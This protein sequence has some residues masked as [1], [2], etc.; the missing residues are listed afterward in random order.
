MSK[1]WP[2]GQ[3]K[4]T[5]SKDTSNP[6]VSQSNTSPASTS[7][8]WEKARDTAI[9][10]LELVANI[11][12]GSDVLASLKA[13]CKATKQILEMARA[14]QNNKEDWKRLAERL[15]SHL[16][17]MENQIT[18]FEGY[19]EESRKVDDSLRQPL[20]AY[21]RKLDGIQKAVEA[22]TRSR[23]LSRGLKVDM[24]AGDIRDFH[25]DINDCHQ[26]LTAALAV[27]S[28]FHIQVVKGDTE[29]LRGDAQVIKEDAKTLLRDADLVII[30]QLP[31]VIASSAV[32]NVCNPG[33]R[34]VVLD[35]IRV[36]GEGAFAEPIFWLCDIAGSGKSTVST[37]VVEF[38]NKKGLLGGHFFFSMASSEES[39]ITK[40]CPTFARQM[41]E[42]IPALAPYVVEAVK[43]HPAIMTRPFEE[44]F[45]KLIVE[46]TR[47]QSTSVILVI[48][49]LDEC[50]SG[51]ERRKLVETLSIAVQE[52]K[53]LKIFITSRPDPV[54]QAVLGSLPIKAQMEDRLHDASHP[55]NIEDIATYIEQVINGMLAE[56]K[57]RRLVK[58]ANG[59][60]IW[61][62]IACRMLKSETTLETHE[63]I[64]DR[65][66]SL[67]QPG[68]IDHIY[69]LI[70][71]RIDP[72]SFTIMFKMLGILLV[73]FEP[74]STDD[75]EDLLKQVGIRGNVNAL[76]QNLGSVLSV[77]RNTNLIRFRHHTLVEYLGRR[78][79]AS[80]VHSHNKVHIN[81]AEAHGQ[82]ASWC[83]KRLVSSTEGVK[84]NIC[85]IESSFYLNRQVAD[86]DSRVSKFI[87]TRLRYASSH[88]LFHF[89]ETDDKQRR[90]L[91][92]DVGR[93][94]RTPNVLHWM[95]IVSLTRG[96]PRAIDGLRTVTRHSGL[97][98]ETR[99]RM[100]DIRR[101]IMAFSVPIQESAAH[102]YISALPFSPKKSLIRIEG[103]SG[104]GNTLS[105]TRGLEE[106]YPGLPGILRGDQGSV[107]AVSFSPDG[108]RIISGSFDKTIRVWDADTGQPLGEP[109]QG[110]EHWVTAVGF[111]PDG[112]I[113]VSGSE[114]K[115][116]RLWE[117]DTGRPLG[118]PLLGHE[119][120]VL[121]VAFS[122]DGSR[123]VSG[124]DD[125]TI[126]LWETDTGQPLGEPL[127]G[128]KSSVSA[129]AFSPDGSRIASASDDKTIRLWEVETGQP[130][131]EPLR[132]HEAGVSAVS[133][134]PDGSQL[135][136]GSIDKTVR[137]WE[138]DT[139][140]LL[141]E[142]LR[143]HED[144]VYAIAFSPDGTKIVSGS[145]DKT[146]RLWER[147]L[148]EPI[149]E[150]LRGH[151][152]CVSTVGFSPDG[153]WVISGS[154]DGTIRLWEVITGQQLGEPPQGHEGSVFTVAFSPDDSKIVSG[155][156]DKTIRLWEADTGQP[157]G[158]PLRGHEGWVN[159]VAFSPDGSLIVS[160]SED[161]TI[162]L[163][164][165]DTG[166]TLREPLR[167]HAGSV[168]AVTFSPD[169]TRIASGSDDDTIRLWEAHTGQPVGQPLRGHERHVNAVMFSPDGTRIV[170][171][172]FDG[173]VR[174]WE[175]DTGQ[176][177]GDPLRGHEVGI[178][179]V[180]FSPDGSRIVS[181]SGDG[182]I[183]LWEA[184]TGQL[185]GEPLKGP[186]LGVNA[187]A[188]SPDGS[189]IVSCSH[190]KTIQF[191]DAN[192]SQ[193]LGEPL[194]GHQSLVFAVAFSSDGSRIV[195]GSSDKTIQIWDT[196]IAASVD[197]SNQNDAEAPE[198]SLQDKLQSSPLSLIVPGFNQCTLSRDGW[199]QSSDK[200]LFWVPPE[201]RHG[202]VY[203]NRLTIPVTS[204]LRTTKVDFTHF[205]CGP[206]WTN[207]RTNSSQ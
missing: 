40:M 80:A 12:E 44:Q 11:S 1:L 159:A 36:W 182:M 192:T 128:H 107:C 115:T 129:V 55:D 56:E 169:G 147:T 118:G 187:L 77:D 123:V 181:A 113:I 15:Q 61:A 122:P 26:R 160:G 142:P 135:A 53:T 34:Q 186:Q 27:S 146:I 18:I 47:H 168:R 155:S 45:Q 177:F 86:L 132:G 6:S 178:N 17:S 119:S 95:E 145:Y 190:D 74:L 157:L 98:E 29:A 105:V 163:W 89:A 121:A 21:V 124:S 22:R 33:T 148:A 207:V 202:L 164:E 133:F 149:G 151:E 69:D 88:W 110:H 189:R 102:I 170:S 156:K 30:S 179:A 127:R 180:A 5:R 97:E 9:P 3:G 82:V 51:P 111:S 206:S 201:N 73:A 8:G 68:D 58:N 138:V 139:G 197:N 199:V 161:R 4:T 205:Q 16:E 152:D 14:I 116:I 41:F 172:S 158:E 136:S 66:V 150:P 19:S 42:N 10:I 20:L 191:W 2:K 50:K 137:L 91:K 28:A 153:S 185:L 112:S 117:A 63:V 130:L 176:P 126:R 79:H 13:A 125:K 76:I 184:D 37:S 194:R 57:K 141:G 167:G 49:A 52:S 131:G 78:S 43:R 71:E 93:I 31:M 67:D 23:L 100:T 70:F 165:V 198:L 143:G 75:L 106:M 38:W 94:I 25:Q 108:S 24:D 39:T 35:S 92:R 196:E 114:D 144:S 96:V 120:P 87:P 85:R 140:Q 171:G 175:A 7:T 103:Q 32:H 59:L 46:P 64:Y 134:S 193:S 48:D 109:L 200:Y 99:A 173:T 162:R 90:A 166:Q 174:L 204:S 65:L 101:F 54:I 104:H 188:F 83:L 60:F 81:V 203:P 72:N 195:S 183:R 154:G 62:S 84:F